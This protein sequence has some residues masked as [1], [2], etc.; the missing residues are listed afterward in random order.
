MTAISSALRAVSRSSLPL[1]LLSAV[2]VSA[3]ANAQ[4]T[5]KTTS[6]VGAAQ[7]A[8]VASG[9]F[10]IRGLKGLFWDGIDKYYKAVEWMPNH[11]MN[12][13]MLCY[14][15]YPESARDWRKDYTAEQTAEMRELVTRGDD[16]GVTICLSFN[17]GIWSDPPLEHSS[18]EDYQAAWRKVEAAHKI[19][20]YWIALCLDDIRREL[21]PADK[22]KYGTLQA[23]QIAFTNRLWDDMQKLSPRPKLIFCPSAY[24]TRDMEKHR[25]YIEY[26]GRELAPEIDI[27]WT[28]P[29]VVSK[30]ITAEDAAVVEKWFRRKPFVWDNYPVN[31]MFHSTDRPWQ[32]LLAPLKHRSADLPQAVSGILFNPMRE[33]EASKIPLVSV[34]NFLRDP[35]SYDAAKQPELMMAEYSAPAREAVEL[36]MKHYGQAFVGEPGFPPAPVM[37]T[38][39]NATASATDLKRIRE[40]LSAGTPEMKQLWEDVKETVEKDITRAEQQSKSE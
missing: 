36:L 30:R 19:G 31:D 8:T 1:A 34:A 11:G 9:A 2:S 4:D 23:A 18:E 26:V 20:I 32:P 14:T 5:T 3:I 10:E 17:P 38:S 33:W 37:D 28:G 40:I 15:A 13:L 27:F 25:D 39:E 12:W 29:D 24:T 6:S 21:T 7:A 16:R 35:R 22:E